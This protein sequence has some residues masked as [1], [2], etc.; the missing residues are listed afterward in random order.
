MVNLRALNLLISEHIKNKGIKN[1]FSNLGFHKMTFLRVVWVDGEVRLKRQNK[2]SRFHDL[3]V[4]GQKITKQ[5]FRVLK[6]C[7]AYWGFAKCFF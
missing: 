1:L 3:K 2:N 4:V 5:K 6:I 7:L